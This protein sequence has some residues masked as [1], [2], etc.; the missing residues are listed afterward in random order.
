MYKTSLRHITVQ[1]TEITQEC[2]SNI[3][4]TVHEAKCA[5]NKLLDKEEK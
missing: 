1:N 2:I 4:F 3:I 5:H